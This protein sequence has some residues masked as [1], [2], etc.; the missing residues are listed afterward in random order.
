MRIV[1]VSVSPLASSARSTETSRSWALI[2]IVQTNVI[3]T[4]LMILIGDNFT[5]FAPHFE[6]YLQSRSIDV[7]DIDI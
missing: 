7:G 4:N 6:Y 2:F 5:K 3:K 1:Y